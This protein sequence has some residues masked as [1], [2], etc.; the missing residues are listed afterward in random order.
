M[1]RISFGDRLLKKFRMLG[2]RIELLRIMGITLPNK[3]YEAL[4]VGP[5][6]DVV[7]KAGF[8]DERLAHQ[9][10]CEVEDILRLFSPKIHEDQ[11]SK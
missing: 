7:H 11:P 8:P 2:G 6:N 3:D 5:R 4:V 10:I 1:Q 9:V